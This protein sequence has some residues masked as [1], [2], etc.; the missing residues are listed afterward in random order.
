MAHSDCPR[1]RAVPSVVVAAREADNV[2]QALAGLL[3]EHDL[4]GL[5]DGQLVPEREIHRVGPDRA[6]WRNR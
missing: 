5:L 2:L 4:D 1:G 6:S 3:H